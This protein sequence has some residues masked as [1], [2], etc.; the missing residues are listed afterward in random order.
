[1]ELGLHS[2]A[3]PSSRTRLTVLI[4][5]RRSATIGRRLCWQCRGARHGGGVG[6][7]PKGQIDRAGI[8]SRRVRERPLE[9]SPKKRAF[10]GRSASGRLSAAGRGIRTGSP[11]RR[12]FTRVLAGGLCRDQRADYEL[13][14]EQT[15]HR[16]S[17][18]Y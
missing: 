10:E 5:T 3:F 6:T 18:I 9:K 2:F 14:E 4:T 11:Q 17:P 15:P 12:S 1:M 8:A 7:S 13:V 16:E